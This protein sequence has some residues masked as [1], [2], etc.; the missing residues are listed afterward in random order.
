MRIGGMMTIHFRASS[1][2]KGHDARI[3]SF[4]ADQ[5]EKNRNPRRNPTPSAVRTGAFAGRVSR[6]RSMNGSRRSGRRTRGNVSMF[7]QNAASMLIRFPSGSV[8]TIVGSTSASFS[9]P[10]EKSRYQSGT[11]NG[12]IAGVAA[13][14]APGGGGAG[15]ESGGGR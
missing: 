5:D 4:V 14:P 8:K 15:G 1:E 9:S 2:M 10:H 7:P 12:W 11:M 6:P 3:R 13:G